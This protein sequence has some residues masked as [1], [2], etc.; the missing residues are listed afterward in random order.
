[1]IQN[2]YVNVKDIKEPKTLKKEEQ[3]WGLTL[4]IFKT[5]YKVIIKYHEIGIKTDNTSIERSEIE[6]IG[7]WNTVETCIQSINLWQ[8]RQEYTMGEGQSLQ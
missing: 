6:Y 7:Q 8:K 3:I 2:L 4:S 1:M 5:Y